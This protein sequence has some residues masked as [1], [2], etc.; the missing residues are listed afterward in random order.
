GLV[1]SRNDI[2]HDPPFGLDAIGRSLDRRHQ[3]AGAGDVIGRR[4]RLDFLVAG[5]HPRTSAGFPSVYIRGALLSAAPRPGAA[6]SRTPVMVRAGGPSI[7]QGDATPT[8][9]RLLDHPPSRMMTG[10]GI[11]PSERPRAMR[12]RRQRVYWIIRLRG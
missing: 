1:Q 11:G 6:Q 5:E 9:S 2:R 7:T 3:R 8:P 10:N 12:H 4:R